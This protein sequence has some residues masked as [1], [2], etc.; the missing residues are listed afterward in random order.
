MLSLFCRLLSSRCPSFLRFS[1]L[2]FYLF[3]DWDGHRAVTASVWVDG[4]L[5]PHAGLRGLCSSGKR[6]C[7]LVWFQCRAF[8]RFAIEPW[9]LP[10]AAHLFKRGHRSNGAVS[11]D[12]IGIICAGGGGGAHAG[13]AVLAP[14]LGVRFVGC[15]RF[16]WCSP[17]TSGWLCSVPRQVCTVLQFCRAL[18]TRLAAMRNA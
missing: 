9:R 17:A 7:H 6:L 10:V 4:W 12:G 14:K 5:V 2:A 1:G 3:Q 13:G 18:A 16:V 15:M 8:G 11:S